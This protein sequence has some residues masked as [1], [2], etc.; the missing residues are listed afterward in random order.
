MALLKCANCGEDI[1]SYSSVCLNCGASTASSKP[2]SE[3]RA[4]GRNWWKVSTLLLA[5]YIVVAHMFYINTDPSKPAELDYLDEQKERVRQRL[6]DP[7]SA[8][9][10][11][12]ERANNP[13]IVCGELDGKNEDGDYSG[14]Q[15]FISV[16]DLQYLEKEISPGTMDLVWRKMCV[17]PH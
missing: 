11:N 7:D 14:W 16:D 2:Q 12:V 15:R 4:S 5:I 13:Y 3:D 9:F 10:R 6:K 1:T 17:D 8:L